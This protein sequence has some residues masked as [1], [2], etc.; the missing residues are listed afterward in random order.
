MPCP[1]CETLKTRA[2]SPRFVADLAR[3]SVLL[4]ERQNP[5]AW[6]VLVLKT[7]AEHM[8]ELSIDAQ[9]DVFGEVARVASAIRGLFPAAGAGG[10]PPR[11]NYECL[12]NQVGHVHWHVIPRFADDPDPR[13]PVWGWTKEMIGEGPGAES[14]KEMA[15]ALRTILADR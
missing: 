11:I 9:R 10:G 15:T 14:L 5:R 6:C 8:A 1:L 7:H 2:A 12:D 4:G 3:T 13:N